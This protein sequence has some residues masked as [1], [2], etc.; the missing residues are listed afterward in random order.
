MEDRCPQCNAEYGPDDRYCPVCG[1]PRPEAAPGDDA[2][3]PDFV[4]AWRAPIAPG[5]AATSNADDDDFVPLVFSTPPGGGWSGG[6][7]RR[8]AARI[9]V[10]VLIA[11]LL[12][13]A[14]G[15]AA[16][17]A[18]G[19]DDA[20]GTTET[21]GRSDVPA[22]VLGGSPH[23]ATPV[24]LASPATG[25]DPA[26]AR[27]NIDSE[28]LSPAETPA[29]PASPTASR[30]VTDSQST[31][32]APTPTATL[33]PPST[34]EPSPTATPS[35]TP[36]PPSVAVVPK[37]VASVLSRIVM[38]VDAPTP[39][40]TS[41]SVPTS[42]AVPTAVAPTRPAPWWTDMGSDPTAAPSPTPQPPGDGTGGAPHRTPSE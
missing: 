28:G 1:T 13:G 24:P 34:V 18:F 14:I 17:Y 33:A 42:T 23:V 30:A 4:A 35:P 10:A 11:L 40:A 38:D 41:A 22:W 32:I 2:S 37:E 27:D 7:R 21:L 16:W 36:G 25:D 9:L 39:V 3:E 5:V 31:S 26:V 12:L 29:A 8:G 20:D 6:P 15:V 19:S